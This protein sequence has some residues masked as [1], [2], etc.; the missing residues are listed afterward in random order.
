MLNKDLKIKLINLAQSANP[1]EERLNKLFTGWENY[2]SLL[3]TP[4]YEQLK[5][6]NNTLK[7]RMSNH[8]NMNLSIAAPDVNSILKPT[9]KEK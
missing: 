1:T 8:N 2:F 4:D 3:N 6:F 7:M 5:E 9:V